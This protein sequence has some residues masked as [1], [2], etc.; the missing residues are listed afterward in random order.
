[1]KIVKS[2]AAALALSLVFKQVHAQTDIPN[3]FKKGTVILFDSAVLSGYVK[4]NTGSSASVWFMASATDKK[5][6]YSGSDLMAAEIDGVSFLCINGDFFKVLC[7]GELSFLQKASDASGKVSYNGATAIFSNGTEGRP[8]D[9]FIYATAA[10]S[11]Q[12]VSKKN[13]SEVAATSFN[14][15]TAAIEKVKTANGDIAQVKDAVTLYNNR[16]K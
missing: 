16:A 14:G 6:N 7:K 5:K 11:L 8:G 2:I 13:M 3:G 4:D 1:M 10:K 9:Y 15:C 12:L